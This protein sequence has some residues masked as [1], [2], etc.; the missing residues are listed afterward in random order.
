MT[1]PNRL[2]NGFALH[3]NGLSARMVFL[4][5]VELSY[6]I[7]GAIDRMSIETRNV[8]NLRQQLPRCGALS[9]VPD[10]RGQTWG[11]QRI[12]RSMIGMD[13]CQ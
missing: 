8:W 3:P 12:D 9:H 7:V 2:P 13:S 6:S 10:I 5:A 11:Q 4:L 1:N